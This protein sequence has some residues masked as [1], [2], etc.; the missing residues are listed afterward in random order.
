MFSTKNF[1]SGSVFDAKS[2]KGSY[3][4]RSILKAKPLVQEGMLWRIG[5]GSRVRVFHE[6]WIPGVFPLKAATQNL[7]F[8]DDSTMSSLIDLE[9]RGWNGQLID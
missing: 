2:S 7:E 5:D 8:V 3:A 1:P 4:W 9:T 6:N